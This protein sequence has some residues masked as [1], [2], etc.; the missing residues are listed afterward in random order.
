MPLSLFPRLT[1]D[2]VASLTDAMMMIDLLMESYEAQYLVP[3]KDGNLLILPNLFLEPDQGL[4]LR[5]KTTK[6]TYTVTDTI[7]NPV[8]GLWEGLLKI[9]S[10]TPPNSKMEEKL[11]FVTKD[12]L[13]RFA[14]EFSKTI[15]VEDQTADELIKDVGPIQ[16]T[17]VYALIK[18]E[19]GSIGKQL[20]GPQKQHKPMH[21]EIIRDKKFSGHSVEIEGQ[22]FDNLVEFGCFTTDNRSADRLADWFERFMRQNTW[23][24]K[25]NGVQ[26]LVF[27]QRLRDTA[28]TKW[29]QDLISR[30]VQYA[31]RIEEILPVVSR[32][33]RLLTTT[34]DLGTDIG[35]PGRRFI[36]GRE[37][38][39]ALSSD[40][41]FKLFHDAA[42][43]YLFGN[44]SLNDGN[45][46][47]T[48]SP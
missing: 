17:I 2:R 26:E 10:T 32:N 25:K 48:R 30:A 44:I 16:P 27:F 22:W 18:K 28:V 39:S 40:D 3:S 1:A 35:E 37:I 19:P 47:Y 11:E 13:V 8:T 9:N 43:N 14:P 46:T 21:R 7:S 20:F 42:G 5:N 45:I 29:R 33:I 31:F 12:K 34:I 36:A 41:Y 24:L 6:E 38:T 23:V 15:G 4:K